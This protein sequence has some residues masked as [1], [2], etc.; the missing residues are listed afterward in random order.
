MNDS[1]WA[2]VQRHHAW[3]TTAKIDLSYFTPALFL[4][5]LA[6]EFGEYAEA[7]ARGVN[8]NT[9]TAY[10]GEDVG[11]EL[12][13]VTITAL[14]GLCAVMEDPEACYADYLTGSDARRLA[15]TISPP[16][17]LTVLAVGLG[18]VGDAVSG[19]TGFTPRKGVYGD[20]ARF[21]SRL[22]ALAHTAR[23]ALGLLVE[24]PEAFLAAHLERSEARRVAAQALAPPDGPAPSSAHTGTSR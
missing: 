21:A 14:M 24:D 4:A 9:G 6:E 10:S 1:V 2:V 18:R 16:T 8:P 22:C 3:F 7:Q 20:D 11:H 5:K 12:C 23:L 13:D 19:V 15:A 17:V